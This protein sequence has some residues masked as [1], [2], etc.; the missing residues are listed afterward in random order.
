MGVCSGCVGFTFFWVRFSGFEFWV[1]GFEFRV[2]G[3][4]FRVSGVGVRGLGFG[5]RCSGVRG[6]GT[7]GDSDGLV[8]VVSED[9]RVRDVLRHPLVPCEGVSTVS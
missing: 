3:F 9:D 4:G 7:G 1:K 8:D 5:V 2:S 6:S